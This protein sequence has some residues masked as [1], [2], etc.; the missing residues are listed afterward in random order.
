[1]SVVIDTPRAFAPGR[2]AQVPDSTPGQKADGF[3]PVLSA[4]LAAGRLAGERLAC[5]PLTPRQRAV[6]ASVMGGVR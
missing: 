2:P 6:V 4:A 1:M 3:D 5:T